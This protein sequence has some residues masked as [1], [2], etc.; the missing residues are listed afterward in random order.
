[1]KVESCGEWEGRPKRT[2]KA[3]GIKFK[4]KYARPG[5]QEP[6]GR[7]ELQ[8]RGGRRDAQGHN[9]TGADDRIDGAVEKREKVPG[10]FRIPTLTEIDGNGG[11]KFI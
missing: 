11:G 1:M 2:Q 4:K 9:Q 8:P 5:Q 6:E 3:W 7:Q 10:A